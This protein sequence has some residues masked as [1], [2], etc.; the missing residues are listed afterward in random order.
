[1]DLHVVIADEVEPV[2]TVQVMK[3]VVRE[4]ELLG[5]GP[6]G[7]NCRGKLQIRHQTLLWLRLINATWPFRD[8]HKPKNFRRAA[9]VGR[10]QF[11]ELAAE[12]Q[13]KRPGDSAAPYGQLRLEAGRTEHQ[14]HPADVA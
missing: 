12:P 3:G 13:P 2:P 6:N 1:M 7:R 14:R 10:R 4:F 9:S 8:T 11:Q 5:A